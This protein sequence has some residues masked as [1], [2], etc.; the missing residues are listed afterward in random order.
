MFF[1][2]QENA[3]V[4]DL[5]KHILQDQITQHMRT[6]YSRLRSGMTVEETLQ[7]LRREGVG[8]K[9]VYFYVLDDDDR[10]LGV[11][12]TRRLLT[13]DPNKTVDDLMVRKV[14][15]IPDSTSVS[16]ACEFFVLHKLLAF[17]VIDD[18]RRI[19]GI[20][21]VNFFTQE[22]FTMT[23]R[24]QGESLFEALGFH[25]ALVRDAGPIRA[26]RYRFPWLLATIASGTLC[27]MLASAFEATLAQSIVLAFFLTLVLG[28]GESVSIQSMTVTIQALRNVRPTFRWYVGALARETGTALL[29][30][31]GCGITVA[32]IC[33]LWRGE[34][35]V[36]VI[37]GMGILS[38]LLAACL[39][40]L[41]IPSLL[42]ALRLDPKIAAGPITLALADL[43]TLLFYFS[44]AAFLLSFVPA[45]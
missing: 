19:V 25:L 30:G 34:P 39:I 24:D 35:L 22:L 6:D 9:I 11:L 5:P 18:Q 40:G 26:F 12:P 2:A 17:P 33:W 4:I 8:E 7:T 44:L 27:A 15:A 43:C 37:I 10:L 32:L 41:S 28:L 31:L 20:V 16:D 29:L 38:S 14:I 45:Q 3:V 36:A 21:D 42:H 1:P 23:E 13:S